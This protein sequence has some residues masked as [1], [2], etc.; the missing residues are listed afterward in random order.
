[1]SEWKAKLS[2]T[3]KKLDQVSPTFCLAKWLQVTLHLQHGHT[4]SC[5]HPIKH[6]IPLEELQDNDSAL[7]NTLYKKIMRKEML[8][9]EAP[10]ECRYC[11]AM[12]GSKEQFFSDRIV[13][14]SDSW[15]I[16]YFDEVLQGTWD[17]DI[18]P[19]YLEVVFGSE[20]NLACAYCAPDTSSRIFAEFQK[21]DAYPTSEPLYKME[22][23]KRFE[24]LPLPQNKNPYI[25]AFWRWFPEVYP[26]LKV[27]RITGGEPLLNPNTFKLLKFIEDNPREDLEISINSNACVE[28]S[29]FQ[30]FV[31][32]VK[33]LSS[34][35]ISFYVSVDTFGE[36][37]EYIRYGLDYKLL[38]DHVRLYHREVGKPVTMMCAFNLLSIPSFT[39]LLKDVLNL[40][41][42]FGPYQT[43]IDISWVCH[44]MYFSPQLAS[45]DLI[46]KLEESL[47]FMLESAQAK[48][49]EWGFIDYEM[50]KFQRLTDLVKSNRLSDLELSKWRKDFICFF[51]EY[52]RRKG[53]SLIK[54]F[55]ELV[56][57]IE[58][59]KRSV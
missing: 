59:I 8:Q 5:H 26:K 45:Q 1:M 35:K 36:Q 57:F 42:E 51:E 48:V 30:K 13:K 33:K 41:K 49:G 4:H 19:R 50:T 39:S 12:E 15:A 56:S 18:I 34:S 52:D 16:P 24:R 6:K 9:G 21:Y 10:R 2:E 32:Q 46:I 11:W 47:N 7:H 29:I 40:K 37:A 54:T 58:E 22:D 27:L 14:S 20:C 44:P 28:K 31:D 3:K 25:D 23:M 43:F 55:P 17:M 53:V 38:M